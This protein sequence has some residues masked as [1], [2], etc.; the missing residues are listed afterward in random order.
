MAKK[1]VMEVTLSIS[2]HVIDEVMAEIGYRVGSV[3]VGTVEYEGETF[4]FDEVLVSAIAQKIVGKI[5][6]IPKR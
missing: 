2:N 3:G 6:I 5:E 1:K 4:L